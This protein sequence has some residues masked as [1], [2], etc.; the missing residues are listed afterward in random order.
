MAK[1]SQK[2]IFFKEIIKIYQEYQ[3]LIEKI[4]ELNLEIYVWPWE[5]NEELYKRQTRNQIATYLQNSRVK[6]RNLEIKFIEK[7]IGENF[8]LRQQDVSIIHSKY[9]NLIQLLDALHYYHLLTDIEFSV[10]SPLPYDFEKIIFKVDQSLRKHIMPLIANNLPEEVKYIKDDSYIE[11]LN[12]YRRAKEIEMQ[13]LMAK[14]NRMIAIHDPNSDKEEFLSEE[15]V[16]TMYGISQQ[17][18]TYTFYQS[19]LERKQ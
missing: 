14:A 11:L 3:K 4:Q 13:K 19:K 6:L 17:D 7:F 15:E 18:V 16:Q 2:A 12:L 10:P 1:E 5:L 8:Q 9:S